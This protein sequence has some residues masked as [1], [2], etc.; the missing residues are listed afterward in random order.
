MF[1][2]HVLKNITY[3]GSEIVS[4]FREKISVWSWNKQLQDSYIVLVKVSKFWGQMKTW[5][6]EIYNTAWVGLTLN[7]LAPTTVGARINP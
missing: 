6:I 1:T 3:C 7:L 2:S 5:D 4:D